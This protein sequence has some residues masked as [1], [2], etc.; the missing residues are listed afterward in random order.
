MHKL[1]PLPVLSSLQ[2]G[3]GGTC[4]TRANIP[5][6]PT[7]APSGQYVSSKRIGKSVT[8]HVVMPVAAHQQAVARILRHGSTI[9]K[10]KRR[11]GPKTPGRV[12]DACTTMNRHCR[13]NELKFHYGLTSAE[14]IKDIVVIDSHI[15]RFTEKLTEAGIGPWAVARELSGA[16]NWHAHLALPCLADLQFLIRSWGIGYVK[17]PDEDSRRSWRATAGYL[18]KSFGQLP[19]GVRFAFYSKGSRQT[20]CD[21]RRV[22]Q[23]DSPWDAFLMGIRDVH[24]R[25]LSRF[26]VVGQNIICELHDEAP[27]RGDNKAAMAKLGRYAM[28][29]ARLERRGLVRAAGGAQKT[30]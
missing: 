15:H 2:I 21:E 1:Q 22:V 14:P 11:T 13:G 18:R 5:P 17:A 28:H 27:T 7:P 29:I 16:G 26:L 10:G 8:Q 3:D 12:K 20:K 9:G 4:Y 23:Q 24:L 19:P 6:T 25:R 30:L